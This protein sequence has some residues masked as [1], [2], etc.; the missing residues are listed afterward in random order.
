MKRMATIVVLLAALALVA[1][2]AAAVRRMR[3]RRARGEG[4]HGRHDADGL[5]RLERPRAER[6]QEGRRGVRQ[7]EPGGH[8]QGRRRHQ[9]RQDHRRHPRRQRAR[10]RSSFTSANVGIFCPSGGWID[11]GPYLKRDKIDMNHLPGGDPLLHAVQGQ[12]LRAAAARRRLRPLLQQGAVQGGRHQRPAEDDLRADDVREEADEEERRRIAQGRG[13]QPV[14]RLLPEHRRRT[15]AAVGAK[16]VDDERQVEPRQRPG[17]GEAAQWQKSLIDWYGYDKLVK[18]QAG[19]RR[20]VLGL[21]R[22]RDGQARDEHRRRVA[23]RVHRGRAPGAQLRHGADAGRRRHPSLYGA[24][25]INGTIIGIPK[26]GKNHDA[27]LGARQVPGDDDQAL[28]Q[29]SNG[30]RNVPTTR[31]SAKSTELK[32][33]A[34][35][36]TFLKIFANPNT[37]TTPITAAGSAT[38]AVQELRRQVAGRQGE[39][40]KAGLKDVDKQIDAQLEQ[41]EGGSSVSERR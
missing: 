4:P 37:T 7:E 19:R 28:A 11:L 16:W 1:V 40:L 12:A 10:R 8:G 36:A 17:L 25:Y 14:L 6:V 34:N 23:R 18:F 30:I 21:E 24:G 3:R 39:D 33:D 35:F 5:G 41:A 32:P 20:R 27:G 22:V 13:L 38:R 26:S 15:S 29:L 9:R 31:A 2:A